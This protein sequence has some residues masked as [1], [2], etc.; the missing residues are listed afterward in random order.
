MSKSMSKGPLEGSGDHGLQSATAIRT[1]TV[2]SPP[3]GNAISGLLVL[4][5]TR[6][7]FAS[8]TAKSTERR[9]GAPS[10]RNK[11]CTRTDWL[12]TSGAACACRMP[13]FPR[14]IEFH[15]VEDARDVALL[16]EIKP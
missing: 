2:V 14:G 11:A 16:L 12:A 3:G 1:S 13:G 5:A 4:P 15:R 6:P 10:L 7:D 8:R 9:M